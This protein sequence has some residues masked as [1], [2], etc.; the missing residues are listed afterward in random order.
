MIDYELG[1][2][3]SRPLTI[4]VRDERDNPVNTSGYES[5]KVEMTD[6]AGEQIDMNGV[7]LFEVPDSL[8]V[9]SLIWPRNVIFDS[10]GVYTLRIVMNT[11][12]GKKDITRT[13]EIRVREYGRMR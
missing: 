6:G 12:D 3:P 1:A 2:I 10:T 11:P 7:A 13:A 9:Y 8:G 5:V 4:V